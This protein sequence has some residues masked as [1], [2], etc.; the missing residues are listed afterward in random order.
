MLTPRAVCGGHKQELLHKRLT[1]SHAPS[2]R[3]GKGSSGWSASGGA[4]PSAVLPAHVDG[5]F[6][7]LPHLCNAIKEVSLFPSP[8]PLIP[9]S[10]SSLRILWICRIRQRWRK[11][12]TN[13]VACR[14]SRGAATRR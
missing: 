5:S 6:R 12:V 14:Q 10:L 13:E 2:G 4:V 1:A 8:L 9:P 7:A 3:E 11:K